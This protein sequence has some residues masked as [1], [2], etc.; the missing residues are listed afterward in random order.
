MHP[1]ISL[2]IGQGIP[3]TDDLFNKK[4]THN[5]EA[6]SK[7]HAESINYFKIDSH[8]FSISNKFAEI[9]VEYF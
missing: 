7:I 3:I 5:N 4:V 2:P 9:Y 8:S 1:I 6:A